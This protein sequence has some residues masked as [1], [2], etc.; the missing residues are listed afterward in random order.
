MKKNEM[1]TASL[2]LGVRTPS[3]RGAV[4]LGLGLGT[5]AGT[6]ALSP[7]VSRP[8]HGDPF[9]KPIENDPLSAK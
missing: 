8:G 4:G 9:P 2:H 3:R 1:T 7:T 5:L 6:V